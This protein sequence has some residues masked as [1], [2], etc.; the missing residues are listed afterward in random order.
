MFLPPTPFDPYRKE[1]FVIWQDEDWEVVWRL[2]PALW[3]KCLH[4]LLPWC[5]FIAKSR[6]PRGSPLALWLRELHCLHSWW[7]WRANLHHLTCT[8]RRNANLPQSPFTSILFAFIFLPLDSRSSSRR[9]Y[10]THHVTVSLHFPG[11]LP[12]YAGHHPAQSSHLLA[13]EMASQTKK[14]FS[15]PL[16]FQCR[17]PWSQFSCPDG[18]K[19]IAQAL[20]FSVTKED[21]VLVRGVCTFDPLSFPVL[22]KYCFQQPKSVTRRSLADRWLIKHAFDIIDPKIMSRR[23]L[24]RVVF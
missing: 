4:T 7:V 16:D 6:S 19:G 9:D 23:H 2:P 13:T 8:D 17:D 14:L 12:L 11:T 3:H 5:I 15:G 1:T 21:L 18:W 22:W 24:E 20:M 10:P